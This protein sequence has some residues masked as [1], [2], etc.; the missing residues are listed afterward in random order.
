MKNNDVTIKEFRKWL[1]QF[2]DET[3][4]EVVRQEPPVGYNS[5]GLTYTESPNISN[6]EIFDYSDISNDGWTFNDYRNN[7]C[8]KEGDKRFGKTYLLLGETS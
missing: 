3:I 7:T 6:K 8:V 5:Y 1:E 4:V 2:P